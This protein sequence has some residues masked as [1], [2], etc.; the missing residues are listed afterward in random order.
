M[1]GSD[2]IGIDEGDDGGGGN[3][4]NTTNATTNQSDW[5]S[6]IDNALNDFM[7]GETNGSVPIIFPDGTVISSNDF[8][9]EETDDAVG[10]DDDAGDDCDAV[11]DDT[12]EINNNTDYD[13][14]ADDSADDTDTDDTSLH[15]DPNNTDEENIANDIIDPLQA[16]EFLVQMDKLRKSSPMSRG[17]QLFSSQLDMDKH[18]ISQH[19]LGHSFGES[20][21]FDDDEGHCY[22]MDGD[23]GDGR[24]IFS[25]PYGDDY[26]DPMGNFNSLHPN[27]TG[28]GDDGADDAPSN[29]QNIAE[30]KEDM[31]S[32][33]EAVDNM[34]SVITEMYEEFQDA[35]HKIDRT[36]A[37]MVSMNNRMDRIENKIDRTED[38]MK[39]LADAIVEL[40]DTL[41]KK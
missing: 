35:R 16:K 27:I 26:G 21:E 4:A 7:A 12:S 5:D 38:Q 11:N 2:G 36:V 20:R 28:W 17:P 8:S 41:R 10:F 24:D 31:D 3:A 14:S 6:D 23:D 39:R 1:L 22:G 15:D 37:M 19:M 40:T 25:N 29:T 13:D 33:K 9:D 30:L 34:D 18:T 32:V